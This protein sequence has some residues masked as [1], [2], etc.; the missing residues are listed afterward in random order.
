MLAKAP[1]E[2]K[3]RNVVALMLKSVGRMSRLVHNVMDFA[4]GRLGGGISLRLT[5][6]PLQPTLEQVVEGMRNV[7]ADRPIDTEFDITHPV[8]VDHPTLP[9]LFS[10]L[11]GKPLILM[12]I[13]DM[14]SEKGYS[15]WKRQRPI[16]HTRS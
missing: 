8:R 1:L 9:Q 2:D 14:I 5:N 4:C 3:A 15:S 12:D 7:W 10:N 11:L 16:R 6:E 13:D